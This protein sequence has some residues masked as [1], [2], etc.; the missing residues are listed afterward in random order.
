MGIYAK[1]HNYKEEST[2]RLPK[3]LSL[4]NLGFSTTKCSNTGMATDK[5]ILSCKTGVVNQIIDFNIA[6]P[7]ERKDLCV[8]NTTSIC[9]NTYNPTTIRADLEKCIGK[10]NCKVSGIKS[11]VTSKKDVCLH[12]DA[13]LSVQFYCH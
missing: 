11:Y 2:E 12:E 9:A 6:S 7:N 10:D 5:I 13:M 4:G 3:L 1:Y 8:R